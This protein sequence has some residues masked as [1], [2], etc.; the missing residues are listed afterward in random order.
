MESSIN[1]KRK[2]NIT[3]GILFFVFF[4]IIGLYPL[5]SNEPIRIWSIIVSLVFLTVTIIK[6]NLF[7]FLNKL[8]IK[9]GILLG[10]IISPIVMGLVFFFVVTPIGIFV[11]ILKKDVMGLKRGQSSYWITREDKIQSMKKQF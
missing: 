2:N 5:I 10:K 4:L 9:F 1:I 6:P 8:W 11:K 7:T 3:F